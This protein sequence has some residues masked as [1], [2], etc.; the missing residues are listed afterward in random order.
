MILVFVLALRFGSVKYTTGEILGVFTQ[1]G[2]TPLKTIVLDSRLPRALIALMAGLNLSVS[3][4]LLQAV[5]RNPLADPGLTGVS[6]GASLVVALILL[7]L[8]QH[9]A[10]IPLAAFLGAAAACF[11]TYILAWNK[12]VDPV[13]IILAGVAVNAVLGGGT[14]LLS[15]LYSDRIQGVMMWLNGSIAGKGWYQVHMLFPYTLAGLIAS[16]LCMKTANALQLG[17]DMAKNLGVR[18]NR[19]RVALSAVAAFIAA[20]SV[21]AVGLIGFIGLVIPHISRLLVGSD[22]KVML[23]MSMLLGPALLIYADTVARTAFSPMELPVGIIMA[24]TGGPFFLWL[25]KKGGGYR[26]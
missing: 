23:P 15:V 5:M 16:L 8:P 6:T 13:R 10:I 14:S 3:G 20:A 7:T 21:S 1:E 9:S 24:I 17:D 19:A 2:S 25:L 4:A 22:Y 18:L 26:V 12:G 11:F